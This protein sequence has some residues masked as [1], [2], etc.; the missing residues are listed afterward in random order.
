MV[1]SPDG[2]DCFCLHS[3]ETFLEKLGEDVTNDRMTHVT[4]LCGGSPTLAIVFVGL[5]SSVDMKR[6]THQ[7]TLSR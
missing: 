1:R 7:S 2:A 6:Q 4:R 3:R 5:P